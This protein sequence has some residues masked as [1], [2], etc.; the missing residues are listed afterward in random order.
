MKRMWRRDFQLV[1]NREGDCKPCGEDMVWSG[2]IT[3]DQV[4]EEGKAR[5]YTGCCVAHLFH[6]TGQLPVSLSITKKRAR[7]SSSVPPP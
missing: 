1:Q 7:T 4:L 5:M 2:L 3:P 6:H